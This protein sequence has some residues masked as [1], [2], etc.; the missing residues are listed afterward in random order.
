[1]PY[2]SL[3]NRK[4]AYE[5]IQVEPDHIEHTAMTTP[6][7]NMVSEVLQQGDCNTMAMY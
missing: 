3:I 1:M 6:D 2:R 7:G 5:Q 4:D